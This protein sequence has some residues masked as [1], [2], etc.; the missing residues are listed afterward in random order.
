MKAA[1]AAAG[2]FDRAEWEAPVAGDAPD[3]ARSPRR[4]CRRSCASGRGARPRRR[5]S[6][7]WWSARSPP[8]RATGPRGSRST[9]DEG[10]IETPNG[11]APLCELELELERGP[12]RRPVRPRP[13]A[14]RDRAA[15]PRRAE[16][17]RAGL[18]ASSTAPCASPSK[19]RPVALDAGRRRAGE[20]FRAIAHACL[21]HLRLQ[22]GRVPARTAIAEALHQMRVA[23]RRLRSAFTLFKPVLAQDPTAA[24]LRDEIKRVTEPFGQAR[25]LDVFLAETLPAEIAPPPGRG[26]PRRPARSASRRSAT[27]PTTRVLATLESPAWRGLLLDL[28]A[29]I[30]T[31]AWRHAAGRRRPRRAGRATSPPTCSTRPAPHPQARTPPRPPRARGAPPGPDRGEEAALRRRVLRQP[32]RRRRS[33]ASAT[34]P[35]S[36]PSP[37]CR[38]ISAP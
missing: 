17:E 18:H 24:H 12:A 26:R 2:L 31:G 27:G 35:S 20:A 3:L 7:P 21:P 19:A 11:D 37:T 22:R 15:A 16:Q 36:R 33:R 28:A 9:L 5:C 23:L 1:A 4:R 38:T 34:R 8:R 30:E 14:G 25:N 10:R 29:W 6:P 13:G 32:L